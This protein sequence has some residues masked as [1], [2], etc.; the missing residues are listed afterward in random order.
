MKKTFSIFVLVP[1]LTLLSACSF[2]SIN[3]EFSNNV[4]QPEQVTLTFVQHTLLRF[5]HDEKMKSTVITF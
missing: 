4:N 2:T 1:L 5:S 3:S